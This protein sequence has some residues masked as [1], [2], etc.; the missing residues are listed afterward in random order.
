MQTDAVAILIFGFVSGV[1]IGSLF[2]FGWPWP[3]FFAT[4]SLVLSFFFGF[5]AA[6]AA[7]TIPFFLFATALGLARVEVES[8]R[9]V[10]DLAFVEGKPVVVRGLV[11]EYPD[12]RE[13]NIHLIIAP[14]TVS[15][16]GATTTSRERLL[17]VADIFPAA[18]YGDEVALY[19]KIQ[20]V[21]NFKDNQTRFDYK[22]YL[23]KR[24]I[25][26]ELVYPKIS[27]TSSGHG[28]PVLATLFSFR[29]KFSA[30]LRRNVEEPEASLGLGMLIGEKHALPPELLDVFKRAGIIHLIVLSGYNITLVAQF[31]MFL[32]SFLPIL[33]RSIF[34][35]AGI[36]LFILMTGGGASAIRAG[37]MAGIALLGVATGRTYD[38]GR[39]L[40]VAGFLMLL[41]NPNILLY[42]SSFQ[43][44]FIATLGLIYLTPHISR[45]LSL[46]RWKPLRELISQT[47]ATQV[48]VLPLLIYLSGLV[49]TVALPVNLLVLPSVPLS[50]LGAAA[51]GAL[52]FLSGT[53]ALPAALMT[54][55][56]LKHTIVTAEFFSSFSWATFSVA[57]S[58]LAVILIYAFAVV[59]YLL[60]SD[61]KEN[62]AH[63][64]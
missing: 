51:S 36:I 17:V 7:L 42:D 33:G 31:L 35:A 50:M 44:S 63:L 58:L 1:V 64:P 24:G 3:A 49:S 38:A 2:H 29:E 18:R 61:K 59:A 13:K 21:R 4:L 39:A 14:E 16:S 34:G 10:N 60:W 9:Y 22:D 8:S 28:N 62:A 12:Q 57:L 30:S 23:E 40:F 48:S 26:H 41:E 20:A 45:R 32:F 27:V 43:L 52:G 53:L 47:L 55:L 56:F 25:F 6:G 19:G 5:R 37:L 54:S 11:T 46:I 15:I